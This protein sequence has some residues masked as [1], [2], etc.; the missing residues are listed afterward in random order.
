[1]KL[2]KIIFPCAVVL[3]ASLLV[4]S[5]KKEKG[6]QIAKES[7]DYSNKALVQVYNGIL[8]AARNTVYV[9]ALPVTGALLAYGGTFPSTPSDFA[10]TAGFRAFLVKDTLTAT[11]QNQISFAENFQAGG[12]YTVFLFD[13]VNAAKQLTVKNDIII[14]DDTTARVR[15]ANI[16]FSRTA[17]ANVDIFSVK[18]NANAFVNVPITGVTNYISYASSLNDTLFVRATGTT[19]NLATLNGFNPTRKRSY[20]LVFRGAYAATSGT[21]IRTLSSFSSN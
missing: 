21:F 2:N 7:Y 10:L 1:M 8:G 5:C 12:N 19:T 14:P 18:R 17:V 9:D 15:F 13:T 11:T 3:A 16:A 20:T 6:Q 4:V